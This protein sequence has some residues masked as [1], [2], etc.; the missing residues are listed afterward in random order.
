MMRVLF[1]LLALMILGC[2]SAAPG[3]TGQRGPTATPVRPTQAA[4]SSVRTSTAPT[5]AP[6][7]PVATATVVATLAPTAS[8]EES[9]DLPDPCTLVTLDEVAAA[10]LAP[11]GAGEPDL[12]STPTL[13][14]GRQCWF[15]NAS[16]DD[17]DVLVSTFA[18][19]GELWDA[20]KLERSQFGPL[21]NLAG[22]GDDAFTIGN[23]EC[24]VLKGDFLMQMAM[25]PADRYA[26]DP[27]PRMIVLCK[28]AA[29]RL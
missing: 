5:A 10:V 2:G 15:K 8:A 25:T 16:G 26:T 14:D 1:G 22:T 4:T 18:N 3:S 24:V 20:Y 12:V 9:A 17:G 7:A 21:K 11:L 23:G 6:S 13:G 29:A 19:P 28:Q 27:E